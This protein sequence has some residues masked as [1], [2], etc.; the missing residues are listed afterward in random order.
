MSHYCLSIASVCLIVVSLSSHGCL[1]V[2]SLLSHCCLMVV[3]VCLTITPSSP[4]LCLSL[5]QVL[6]QAR[7]PFGSAVHGHKKNKSYCETV[8]L[9][10]TG[11]Y[12]IASLCKNVT[13]YLL[14]VNLMDK[15]RGDLEEG[16]ACAPA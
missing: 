15:K 7:F 5:S 13:F 14:P 1:M 2:V 16:Q 6:S 4:H 10:E 8:L 3:S 12:L 9:V 11:K